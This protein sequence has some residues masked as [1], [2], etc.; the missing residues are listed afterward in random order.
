MT[1]S[2]TNTH[3]DMFQTPGQLLRLQREKIGLS[4]ED[5]AKRI[6]LDIKIIEAIEA[7]SEDDLPSAIYVRGYL[8]SY[9]K[10]IDV[11]ADKV[12]ELY[13]NATP[14]T[15]PDILPEVKPPTQV[16]SN[17]KPVK[18]FTYLLTLG[19]VLLLLIWYQSNFVVEVNT[20]KEEDINANSTAEIND[21]DIDYEV[22]I[23]DNTSWQSPNV[24]QEETLQP[25]P[26]PEP[27]Q[28]PAEILETTEEN[29]LLKL[30]SFN[31]EQTIEISTIESI[32]FEAYE[33]A[34]TT[35][36]DTI[37]MKLS[38]DS[39]IEILDKDNNKTFFDLAKAGKTYTLKGN[40]PFEV[41]LGFAEGVNL[42]F[43]EGTVDFKSHIKNGIARF[44]LPE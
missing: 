23:H 8:R 1:E 19:L 22:I 37:V 9:A 6:H 12:I 21:V 17:D 43:N 11:D 33:E 13:N 18:A 40:A 2:S 32:E 10:T 42:T 3:Q 36:N 44:T 20:E 34:I 4:A 5:I 30:Q 29:G 24:S 7:D 41:L 38:D 28:E 15:L 35:G 39:W 16:S 14:P 27:E 25:K 26:E 31:E